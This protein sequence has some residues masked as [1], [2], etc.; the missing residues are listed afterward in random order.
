MRSDSDGRRWK[1]GL[2]A[3]AVL[4]GIAFAGAYRAGADDQADRV[5]EGGEVERLSPREQ[6]ERELEEARQRWEDREGFVTTVERV[7]D[8]PTRTLWKTP[9]RTNDGTPGVAPIVRARLT[10]G[11]TVLVIDGPE[12]TRVDDVQMWKVTA[13][14]AVGWISGL[15][16]TSTPDST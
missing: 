1:V 8:M 14:R 16:L 13:G 12:P 15:Q 5:E 10:G 6:Y 9:D 7:R 2:A 11:D 4:A 3:V